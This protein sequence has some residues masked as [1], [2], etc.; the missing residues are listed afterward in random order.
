MRADS[1]VALL[2]EFAVLA[3][4]FAVAERLAPE[5]AR[6]AYFTR[7]RA[8]DWAWWPF[9]TF[10]TGNLTR[11]LVVG[12]LAFAVL[13][14]THR[15]IDATLLSAWVD[16]PRWGI[17]RLPWPLC[18]AAAIALGDLLN[19]W[20]HR[21]RHTRWLWPFHAVHHSPRAL[22]W[23]SAV[24]MHPVDDAVDNVPVGIAL[25]AMGA[26]LSVWLAT[27]PFLLFFN[28]WLHANIRCDLGP[29]R[30][31]LATPSFHRRHH[32]D[33]LAAH[34]CNFAGVLPIWDLAFG[35]FHMPAEPPVR[36]G[37]GDTAVPETLA[38]QLAFPFRAIADDLSR[39]G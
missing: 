39:A 37:A 24:R 1:P 32:A 33:E 12:A 30:Y 7:S 35:T 5:R 34:A 31:V 21:L 2:A 29:L 13:A 19:Y 17:G 9:S 16:G 3:V 25:L 10:V 11:A 26:P 22:D 20:N 18:F 28:L 36:F 14:G 4:V 15:A 8:V 23:L 38:G 6:T 27:G